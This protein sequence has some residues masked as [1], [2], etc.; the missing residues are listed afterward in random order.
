MLNKIQEKINRKLY[1]LQFVDASEMGGLVI[2]T[3]STPSF[4]N[5]HKINLA[6]GIFNGTNIEGKDTEGHNI[7]LPVEYIIDIN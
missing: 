7:H 4:E 3:N 6:F 2:T 1:E 5:S